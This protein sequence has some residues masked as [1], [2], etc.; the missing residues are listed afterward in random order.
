MDEPK[1][2]GARVRDR[3]G[4]TWRRGCTRWTCEAPVDGHRVLR[5]GRLPWHALVRMDGPLTP[6]DPPVT[7][8]E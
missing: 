1:Q 8:T 5:V 2:M 6:T 4:D 7:P 3:D